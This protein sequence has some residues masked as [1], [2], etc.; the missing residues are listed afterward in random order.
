MQKKYKGIVPPA[1]A[2]WFAEN[3]PR[4]TIIF[5]PAWHVG[6]IFRAAY[7]HFSDAQPDVQELVAEN[8]RLSEEQDHSYRL[9]LDSYTHPII[10]RLQAE[11]ERLRAALE[12]KERLLDEWIGAYE[13]GRDDLLAITYQETSRAALEEKHD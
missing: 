9:L 11:N 10:E 1:F 5:D 13:A 12:K 4:D 7:W 2:E 8:E 6:P 3:Y